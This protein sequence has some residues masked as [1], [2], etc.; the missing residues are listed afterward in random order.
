MFEW[1]HIKETTLIYFTAFQFSLVRFL[2]WFPRFFTWFI[3]LNFSL[4]YLKFPNR[5]CWGSVTPPTL[6]PRSLRPC[7]QC[8]ILLTS[9][10]YCRFSL[11]YN[12]Y[13]VF[14]RFKWLDVG[15][16]DYNPDN[17]LFFVRAVGLGGVKHNVI[18]KGTKLNAYIQKDAEKSK[19]TPLPPSL[20]IEGCW[21]PRIRL[22]FCAE[23][24][25][26]FADRVANAYNLRLQ[27]EALLRWLFLTIRCSESLID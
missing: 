2:H 12:T 3:N 9:Q 24:P 5:L 15:V 20:T 19:P 17:K 22:M 1:S 4:I 10:V 13:R 11:T 18:P 27:T 8:T 26:A 21:I 23:D 7:W 14:F 16:L 6:S 25:M